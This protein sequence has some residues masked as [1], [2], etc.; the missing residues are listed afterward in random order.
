MHEDGAETLYVLHLNDAVANVGVAVVDTPP[1]ALVD[2]WFLGSA[3]ENDVQGQAGTPVD[4]NNLTADFKVDVGAAGASFPRQQAFYVA[5][6]SGRDQFSGKLLAGPYT[7]RAWI[8]DVTPPTVRLLTAR[9]AAGRP[10]LVVRVTDAGSGVDPL[11]LT[12]GYRK[13]LLGAAAYDATTGNAVVPLPAAAPALRPG[14]T[15]AQIR[16]ADFQEAK[17]VNTSGGTI[18]PNTRFAKV[19]IHVVNGPAVTWVEASCTRLTVAASSTKRIREVRFAGV[20]TVR[21]GSNGLYSIRRRSKGSGTVRATAV[22]A[23]GRTASALTRLARCP[24]HA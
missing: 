22:D 3:D 4:V 21:R 12:L 5:V 10:T 17:N 18:F 7:L 16:A 6:D 1:G 19:R 8:D 24:S 14:T 9:V 15:R 20:G 13:V 11:S 2:P 23:A